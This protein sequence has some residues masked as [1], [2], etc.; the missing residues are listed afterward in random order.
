M[1]RTS[2]RRV[3]VVLIILETSEFLYPKT[4]FSKAS[5]RFR[6]P[7]LPLPEPLYGMNDIT[8]Y[9]GYY[10]ETKSRSDH[11]DSTVVND[12]LWYFPNTGLQTLPVLGY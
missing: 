11:S 3:N 12:A 5:Q 6:I 7:R 8:S 2:L 4:E 9:L 1:P 10:K